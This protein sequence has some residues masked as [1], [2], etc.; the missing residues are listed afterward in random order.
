MTTALRRI[1]FQ[2]QHEKSWLPDGATSYAPWSDELDAVGT[3]V[4]GN[5]R[6]VIVKINE[7]DETLHCWIAELPNDSELPNEQFPNNS[8]LRKWFINHLSS[9]DRCNIFVAHNSVSSSFVHGDR[10]CKPCIICGVKLKTIDSSSDTVTDQPYGGTNFKSRGH[11]GSTIFDPD[12]SEYL[13]LNFCDPCLHEKSKQGLI[14]HVVER[15]VV[16][17]QSIRSDWSTA[18]FAR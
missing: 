3:F 10:Y 13:S 17:D 15:K 4:I 1:T 11:Y 9:K 2:Q 12:S 6:Y 14:T 18:G 16:V 7:Q 5:D 8:Q